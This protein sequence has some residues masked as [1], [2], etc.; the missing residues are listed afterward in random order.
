MIPGD[1]WWKDHGEIARLLRHMNETEC[2]D[3]DICIDVVSK[4][5]HWDAEYQAMCIEQLKGHKV[6]PELET[7]PEANEIEEEQ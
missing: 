7:L 2:L 3:V 1:E 6:R 4:P 5:W